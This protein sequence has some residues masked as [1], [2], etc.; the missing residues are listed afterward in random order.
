MTDESAPPR[1]RVRVWDVP[2]RFVHWSMVL[3]VGV[4][5]WTGE[6]G[7]LEWHRWSGYLLLGLVL[8]RV[9]WG[10]FG[11]ATARF[12]AFVRG[13]RVV[14]DYLRGRWATRPG[15]NPLGALSVLALLA[16]LALQIAL[17]LFAVDVDGIESGPLSAYVSFETGRAAA[18]WH[19]TLFKVLLAVIALH[20]VAI[21]WYRIARGE[22]LL[23]AMLHGHRD[24]P[25]PLPQPAKASVL[26]LVVGAVLAA[27]LTW[28]VAR[29]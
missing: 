11:S 20:I 15:H 5:W 1:T 26:R 3:G 12:R 24:F 4:S 9:Y 2:T 28:L 29:G 25:L 19:D 16:L 14:F 10:L 21:G 22:K 8:F 18:E 7:R 6:T 27:L 23:G 17:G 13:P